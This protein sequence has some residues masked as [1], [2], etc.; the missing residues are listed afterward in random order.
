M[1]WFD[2]ERPSKLPRPEKP[3]RPGPE[4]KDGKGNEAPASQV[5]D[6]PDGRA[7][8]EPTDRQPSGEKR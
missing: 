2:D 8:P 1:I 5:T 3:R 6:G 7:V 4:G